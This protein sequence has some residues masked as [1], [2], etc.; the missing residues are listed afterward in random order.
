M[1]VGIVGAEGAK[2]T[3]EGERLAKEYISCILRG[4][5]PGLLAHLPHDQLPPGAAN[6]VLISGGCHLGGIDIWAEEE[7]DRLG[8]Y[9]II[10]YPRVQMWSGYRAR[11]ILIA[12]DSHV[13][14][15]I[16]V[17]RLPEGFLGMRHKFCYHC[18]PEA[19]HVKSG[20]CWTANYAEQLGKKVVRYTIQQ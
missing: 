13:L 14:H 5:N 7:A 4:L 11:N 15:N 6:N 8:L 10:H 20:G 2:F 17:N 19:P 1:N 16:T 18:G 12:K 3:P 9:K